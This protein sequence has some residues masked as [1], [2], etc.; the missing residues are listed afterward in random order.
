MMQIRKPRIQNVNVLVKIT[1]LEE[2]GPDLELHRLV[3][4]ALPRRRLVAAEDPVLATGPILLKAAWTHKSR[5]QRILGTCGV[6]RGAPLPEDPGRNTGQWAWDCSHPR[7]WTEPWGSKQWLPGT[8]P[9]ASS[10][11]PQGYSG[12]HQTLDL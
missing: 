4:R 12:I 10:L 5:A 2:L 8:V 1:Q 11:P 3:D 7:A 6:C 9:A